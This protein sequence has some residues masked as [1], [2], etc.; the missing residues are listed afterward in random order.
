MTLDLP[1]TLAD[2]AQKIVGNKSFSTFFVV[3]IPLLLCF[4]LLVFYFSICVRLAQL[5]SLSLSLLC[6]LSASARCQS[7]LDFLGLPYYEVN[8]SCKIGGTVVSIM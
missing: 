2:K 5:S 4:V 6:Q 8:I 3:G 7:G 1:V